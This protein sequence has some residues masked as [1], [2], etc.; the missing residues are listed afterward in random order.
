MAYTLPKELELHTLAGKL[1]HVE[2]ICW[3]PIR[4][5]LWAGGEAGQVYRIELDGSS[6]IASTIENGFLLGIALDAAGNLYIC[7]PGNHCV[8]RVDEAG[9]YEIYG[10]E[11]NY[12]NYP[13]FVPDGRLFV[14]DSGSFFNPSGQL[15]VIH[16][17]GEMENITPRTINFANGLC[18]DETTLWMVESSA[19]AVSAMPING[20]PLE[21]V[22]PLERCVPDGLA[23]D[24][25]GGI[26][27]SCY[28]PN[29]LLRWSKENGLQVIFEDWT[30][31]SVLSP[32]NLAFYGDHLDRI[33][34]ASLCGH[35]ATSIR[36]PFV[37]VAP[38]YPSL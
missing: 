16:P 21:V 11:I 12:P 10:G 9:R 33:A 30:G 3:D 25:K 18:A 27:I 14:S 6:S 22:I 1:D 4:R 26:L 7:D 5:C 28:Q 29:Q 37:G 2:G 24:S 31:E 23:R 36:A 20:G 19:P 17:G 8:W 32:T 35:N 13:T 34:L 15:F 38:F